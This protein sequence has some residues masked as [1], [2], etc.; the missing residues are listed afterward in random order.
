LSSNQLLQQFRDHCQIGD[1]PVLTSAE[2]KSGFLRRGRPCNFSPNTFGGYDALGKP[3]P[4]TSNPRNSVSSCWRDLRK[5]NTAAQCTF[6][7]GTLSN[8]FKLFLCTP[9]PR[10]EIVRTNSD[11]QQRDGQ[12]IKQTNNNSAVAEMVDRKPT[13][14]SSSSSSSP[15]FSW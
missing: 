12:T 6:P 1:R 5:L 4:S 11:V 13:Q 14:S 15:P 9:T 7:Y 10:G 3:D 2:S 8:T